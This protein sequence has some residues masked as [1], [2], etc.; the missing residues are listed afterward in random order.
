ML[1]RE[2]IKGDD[3]TMVV[4]VSHIDLCCGPSFE[5]HCEIVRMRSHIICF[6]EGW[7]K[8]SPRSPNLNGARSV[9]TKHTTGCSRD[10]YLHICFPVHGALGK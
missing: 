8:W 10:V 1:L 4:N 5:Q 6:I 7:E 9:V 3:L 2:G